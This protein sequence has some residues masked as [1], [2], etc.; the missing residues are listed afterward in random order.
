MNK[1]ISIIIPLFTFIAVLAWGDNRLTIAGGP[2]YPLIHAG[3]GDKKVNIAVELD[4]VYPK[5]RL[6]TV[7]KQAK[8][9]KVVTQTN[10]TLVH[11]KEE[12]LTVSLSVPEWGYYQYEVTLEEMKSGRVLASAT[13][14]LSVVP[15]RKTT[16]PSDFG[17]CTHFGHGKGIVPYSLDLIRLAGFS[18]I[19]DE[20]FWDQVEKK[21]GTFHF[22]PKYDTYVNAAV[23]R[24]IK[25]LM[26]LDYGNPAPGEKVAHAGFPLDESGRKRFAR[27]AKELVTRYKDRIFLWEL[28]NEPSRTIGIDPDTSY[29][30]L[31]KETYPVIKSIQPEGEFICSG[32]APNLVDGAF[33]NPIFKRG[34]AKL[35]DG[36]AM[37]TYVAPYNPEDGYKTDGHPFL[38]NVSVPSLWPHYGEMATLHS[39]EKEKPIDVWITE[40]GWHLADS[41]LTSK[42]E[43]LFINEYRQAAYATRLFL[44]SRRYNTTRCVYL[45]DFQNDGVNPKER[46]HNFGIIRS[47]FSP[48]AAYSAMAVLSHLLDTKKFTKALQETDDTKVFCYGEGKEE[49]IAL[50]TVNRYYDLPE[51]ETKNI[52]LDLGKKKIK[53]IDWQ[54]QSTTLKSRNGKYTLPIL[55]NPSFI[56]NN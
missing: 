8:T 9:G 36:F 39:K 55:E 40:M 21:I 20:I 4:S 27:Y 54:G 50:W 43:P 29:F 34:G 19:R 53:L 3:I 38:K 6:V 28:W 31:L 1:R 7:L 23:E 37:H 12:A 25:V 48:K 10:K 33:V 52:T 18:T 16:G 11:C 35:M 14:H 32:G 2:A 24:D 15:E 5:V 17:T 45:Y 13:S 44:L 41:M 46:E 42:G 51:R 22:D 30:N 49:V 26:I 56:V 47:D